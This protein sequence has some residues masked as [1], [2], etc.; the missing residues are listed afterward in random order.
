MIQF[1]KASAIKFQAGLMVRGTLVEKVNEKAVRRYLFV[2]FGPK[3][4]KPA[5]KSCL[6]NVINNKT[7][8]F[9]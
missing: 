5:R 4:N 7:F 2:D 3:S 8:G 6:T 1:R 9:C